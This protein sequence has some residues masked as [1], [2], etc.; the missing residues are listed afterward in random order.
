MAEH[1][2]QQ[3]A[4][5]GP[6]AMLL[7]GILDTYQSLGVSEPQKPEQLWTALRIQRSMVE[8]YMEREQWV[9]AITLLREWL[10]SWVMA[11][12]GQVNLQSR[13]ARERVEKEIRDEANA[14]LESRRSDKA[15]Q[16]L[17]LKSIGELQEILQIW[18]DLVEV[19][20]DIDHAGMRDQPKD[21]VSLVEQ[22]KALAARVDG[23]PLEN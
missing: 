14:F 17:F 11:R 22:I 12:I 10:V 16:P 9:Q 15:F 7:E 20:N 13:S 2:L 18:I 4:S 21:A 19:R 6:F 3:Y 23:I 8:W 5:T 1:A